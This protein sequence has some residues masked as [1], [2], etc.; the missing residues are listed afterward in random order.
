MC[1]INGFNFKDEQLLKKMVQNTRHRGPDQEGFYWDNNVSLGQA[2][3]SII[4]LSEKGRQPLW[5]EDK[6]I[7]VIC[8]GEIYNFQEIRQDLQK[9]GHRFFSQ[10]DS[11]VI[12]HFYEEKGEKCLEL[13][14]GIFAFCIYDK[15]KN[16]L[17]L[18]RDRFGVKPLYYYFDPSD[19]VACEGQGKF[20]FSSEIKGI[21]TH[22]IKRVLNQE[23]L[24]HHFRLFFTP[25]PF[26]LFE[27]IYKLPLAHYLVFRQGQIEIKK[28][29]DI[30]DALPEI[31]TK[32]EAI[33]GLRFLLKQA[34]QSQLVSDRPVGIF[35]SGGI[36]SS[37]VLA[38]ARELLPRKIKTY[39]VGFEVE[40]QQD[41]YN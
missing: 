27:K 17:F 34:V 10:S 36:D 31:K 33:E 7:A 20:I 41:K 15:K 30:S 9:K 14:N 19:A 23:A 35:L 3:L 21:L 1:S 11:E 5:N 12:L 8:D 24:R 2:R 16:K 32:D 26:T 38:M 40:V 29:W 39:S 4:D 28:Y 25:A 37:S 6:S 13:L 22:P 18:A